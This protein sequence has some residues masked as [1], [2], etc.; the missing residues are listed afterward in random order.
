MGGRK[1]PK[2]KQKVGESPRMEESRC[3]GCVVGKKGKVSGAGGG[4][5]TTGESLGRQVP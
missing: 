1:Q 4:E 3:E 2:Q 5:P